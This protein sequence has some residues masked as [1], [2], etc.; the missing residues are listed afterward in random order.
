MSRVPKRHHTNT[1]NLRIVE[2]VDSE[3]DLNKAIEN[4]HVTLFRKIERNPKLY[5]RCLLLRNYR[6]GLYQEVPSRSFYSRRAGKQEFPESEWECMH[7]YDHYHRHRRADKAW[8]A[9]VLPLLPVVG[10]RF[11][12]EG[13]IEDIFEQGFWYK[14]ISA[15]NAEAVWN[16]QDLEIDEA[17][18]A[19]GHIVG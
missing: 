13:I 5:S 15:D 6:S 8:A 1:E 16:G 10:E 9:Y 17:Q 4:G 11:Y 18:F 14:P 12:I 7:R 3:D 19:K 2:T